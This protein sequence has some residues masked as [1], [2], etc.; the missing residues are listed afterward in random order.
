MQSGSEL[1]KFLSNATEGLMRQRLSDNPHLMDKL[2]PQWEIGCRRLS[3]G[4]GYLEAMQQS[5]AEWCFEGIHEIT[6]TGIRTANGEQEF[7]LIVCAT[8]FDTTFVPGWELVGRNGRRLDVEWKDR[9]EAYFSMCTAAAPNYFMFGG[10]NCPVGHGSLPQ[11]LSWS[12]DYMLKWAKKMA[13]ED[14]K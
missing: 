7:D 12:A 5:N 3:P 1:N 9:P 2:I 14:I 11:M 6:K 13:C 10:P 8:G 4:D